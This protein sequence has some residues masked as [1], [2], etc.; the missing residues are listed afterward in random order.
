MN[1]FRTASIPSI[2]GRCLR[3]HVARLVR[4]LDARRHRA[5]RRFRFAAHTA[6]IAIA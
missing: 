3:S 1:L 6:T 2:A 4:R 5:Q